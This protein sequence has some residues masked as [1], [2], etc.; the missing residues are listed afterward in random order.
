MEPNCPTNLALMDPTNLAPIALKGSD[1]NGP[2]EPKRTWSQRTQRTQTDL[3]PTDPKTNEKG[4]IK[5]S[6]KQKLQ[7]EQEVNLYYFDNGQEEETIDDMMKRKKAK[8]REKRIEERKKQELDDKFDFDTETVIGMTNK[9]KIKQEEQKKKEFTKQQRKRNRM[10]KRI[11]R[12]VRFILLLGIITGAIVFATC[13]PI[14]NITDIEVLN[15]NMVS[16]DTVISLSG[17]RTNENIFRFIATKA[18][19]SIKQNAYIEDVKIRRVIPNKVQIE[20]TEREPQFSIPVLGEFAYM[21]TQGYIL[22]ITQNELNL[23]IIYG[24]QTPE[25]NIT[26]GNRIVE[27]DLVSLETVLKIMNGMKDSGLAEK[28]T[29]IDISN[30]NDYSIYMQEEKKTIH[31]GDGSNL[32]NKMLYV[33]AILEEEKDVAGEIFANGDLNSDFRVYFREDV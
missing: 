4:G 9:N 13:S 31:L 21:S 12:I 23:P 27:Q 8:E 33:I 24:L 15:N 28:I 7:K 20:V 3:V 1:P 32:S 22:E 6:K 18:S 30:K 26:V 17:I 10:I 5:L 2:N 16:S 19:N 25:E 29:S 14:F 11:K